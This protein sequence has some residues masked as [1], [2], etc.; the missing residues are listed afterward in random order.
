MPIYEYYCPENHTVYQFLVRSSACRALVPRCPEN[1][2]YTLQKQ[3]SRFAIIGKAQEETAD[4]PFAGLDESQMERLMMEMENDMSGLD[5]DNP[6][7]RQLGHFMGKITDMMG[8]KAP[9][10]LR[11]V[12]RRLQA[13]EDPEKLEAQFSGLGDDEG[14]DS[15]FTQARK[16]LRASKPPTRD[17]KLYDLQH[18]LPEDTETATA[19]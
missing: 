7:P 9:P 3:V 10:E 5:E 17:P 4:D 13:G 11:E 15:L 2:S 1:P 18:W 14:A 16:I 12:V 6:D 19:S 8:D